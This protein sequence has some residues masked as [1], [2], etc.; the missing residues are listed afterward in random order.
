MK[1][2]VLRKNIYVSKSQV[3]FGKKTVDENIDILQQ[4]DDKEGWIKVPIVHENTWV[5]SSGI[6]SETY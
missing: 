5:N 4:W 2:R 6:T 1:L 3:G